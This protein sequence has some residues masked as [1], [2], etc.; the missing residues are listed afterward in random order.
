MAR[1]SP[2]IRLLQITK[3]YLWSPGQD[4]HGLHQADKC[5]QLQHCPLHTQQRTICTASLL[6]P[7]L[8]RTRSVERCCLVTDA[9]WMMRLVGCWSCH[10]QCEHLRQELC[11]PVCCEGVQHARGGFGE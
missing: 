8:L 7:L 10:R 6:L 4:A 5:V 2:T 9:A 1:V 11:A 3:E